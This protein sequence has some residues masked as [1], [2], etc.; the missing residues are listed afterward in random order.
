VVR[1]GGGP[2]AARL[3]LDHRDCVPL[4]ARTRWWFAT[5]PLQQRFLGRTVGYQAVAAAGNNRAAK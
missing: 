1:R 3:G 4:V 5:D 2:A